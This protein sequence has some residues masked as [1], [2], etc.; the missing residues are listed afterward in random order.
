MEIEDE[1]DFND[2]HTIYEVVAGQEEEVWCRRKIVKKKLERLD[3]L[4]ICRLCVKYQIL[5][6]ATLINDVNTV[7]IMKTGF[8]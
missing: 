3:F 8:I 5:K 1:W 2:T 6:N 4:H 7:R